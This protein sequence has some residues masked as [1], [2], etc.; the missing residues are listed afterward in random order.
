M[1]RLTTGEVITKLNKLLPEVE[2]LGEYRNNRTPIKCRCRQ[3]RYEWGARWT[4][5]QYRHGCP[6]C[7]LKSLRYT[8]SD[9]VSELKK[10]SPNI[11]ILGEYTNA[12]SPIP[13]K[14]LVC[15]YEWSPKWF[16][17]RRGHGCPR[18]ADKINGWPQR[19]TKEYQKRLRKMKSASRC[20]WEDSKYRNSVIAGLTKPL[21]KKKLR[22]KLAE[23]K[24]NPDFNRACK[25][26]LNQ[27]EVVA[28]ISETMKSKWGN[29]K[30]KKKHA[31]ATLWKDPKYRRA[32]ARAMSRPEVRQARSQLAN[33]L[34]SDPK[35]AKK[36][37]LTRREATKQ[38]KQRGIILLSP[39]SGVKSKHQH[40]LQCTQCKETWQG[41]FYSC[42]PKCRHFCGVSEHKVRVSFEALTK[43]KFPKA[44]PSKVTWLHGLHLD[45]YCPTL[46]SKK[47]PNG[48]AFEYQ[49]PQHYGVFAGIPNDTEAEYQRRRKRDWRK[50][51]QCWYHGVRL[52]LVPYWVK[53]IEEYLIQKL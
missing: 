32:H 15:S 44:P 24:Q 8:T 36:H 27:P 53:N 16:S 38:L 41:Q 14:C 40:K 48:T 6:R 52:I 4:T 2:L 29:P 1:S 13:C 28:K 25:D 19:G 30:Y 20:K 43:K 22:E 46:K 17:L 39:Y 21:T 51:F 12:Q 37:S 33:K 3:C 34:W 26:G 35:Y 5:L 9:A 31:A 11:E 47:F 50:K 49:G 7:A 42:C 45:G 18:C 23:Q 10:I